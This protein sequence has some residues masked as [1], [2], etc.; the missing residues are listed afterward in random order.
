MSLH[1]ISTQVLSLSPILPLI[2]APSELERVSELVMMTVLIISTPCYAMSMSNHPT[3]LTFTAVF[4]VSHVS[5]VA[6]TLVSSFRV[7]T[8]RVFTARESIRGRTLVDVFALGGRVVNFE[9]LEAVLALA[10]VSAPEVDAFRIGSAN[11]PGLTLVHIYTSPESTPD[12]LTISQIYS[13]MI[14]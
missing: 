14:L 1:F 7:D 11:I 5:F 10:P 13:A 3:T 2:H 4:S 12:S 9:R 8:F 6:H